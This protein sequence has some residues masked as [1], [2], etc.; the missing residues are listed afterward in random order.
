MYLSS[1]NLHYQQFPLFYSLFCTLEILNPFCFSSFL[2]L[3]DFNVNFCNTSHYLYSHLDHIS[4]SFCLLQVVP[5]FTH[6]KSNGTKSLIDLAFLS[7]PSQLSRCETVSPLGSSD[8][9]GVL[10][11]FD[12]IKVKHCHPTKPRRIVWLYGQA[13]FNRAKAFNLGDR[14]G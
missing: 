5:S 9:L 2:L 7:D 6:V 4:A 12:V 10:L 14:L 3:G 1:I 11:L 13:D 8:H